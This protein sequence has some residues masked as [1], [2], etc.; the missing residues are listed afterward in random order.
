MAIL[1]VLWER[2]T[3]LANA[4]QFDGVGAGVGAS[5]TGDWGTEMVLAFGGVAEV[6]GATKF[7]PADALAAGS[8][9]PFFDQTTRPK[10]DALWKLP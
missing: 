7:A 4:A 1:A 10:R 6:A 9:A 5:F 3:A 8:G 2:R